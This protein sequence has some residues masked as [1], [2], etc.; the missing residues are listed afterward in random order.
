MRKGGELDNREATEKLE[1]VART[2][3]GWNDRAP[4]THTYNSAV[5][6]RGSV[7]TGYNSEFG[8]RFFQLRR[9]MYY[10]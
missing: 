7:C 6:R 2:G 1:N 10:P 5:P 8:L 9:I 3:V 4:N